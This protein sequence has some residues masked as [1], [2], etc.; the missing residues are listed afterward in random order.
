MRAA[1][2]EMGGEHGERCSSAPTACRM[3][4]RRKIAGYSVI[5]GK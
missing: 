5:P 4:S 1:P 3:P 2:A